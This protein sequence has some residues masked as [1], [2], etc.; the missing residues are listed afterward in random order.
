[1]R[2]LQPGRPAMTATSR[3]SRGDVERAGDAGRSDL[4]RGR[5]ASVEGPRGRVALADRRSHAGQ[6]DVLASDLVIDGTTPAPNGSRRRRHR[7]E[8][9]LPARADMFAS[10][11]PGSGATTSASG[12][13]SPRGPS[14]PATRRRPRG[15]PRVNVRVQPRV[16]G[17]RVRAT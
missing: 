8:P 15:R 1:M 12:S 10:R 2:R 3:G 16:L 11:R 5:G 17:A 9:G 7:A 13:T 4:G 6:R 14:E